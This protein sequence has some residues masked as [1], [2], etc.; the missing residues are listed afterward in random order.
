MNSS[1]AREHTEYYDKVSEMLNNLVYPNTM[2]VIVGRPDEVFDDESF[3]WKALDDI[4]YPFQQ[5]NRAIYV[6]PEQT[7]VSFIS[8]LVDFD[9]QWAHGV[10]ITSNL[11]RLG[12]G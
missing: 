1:L 2:T 7:Q 11:W 4:Y 8:V 3:K 9:K 5:V 10:M 6:Y 12:I